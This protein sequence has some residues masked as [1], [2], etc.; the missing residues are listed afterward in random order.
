MPEI[1]RDFVVSEALAVT[2]QGGSFG[3]TV[4]PLASPYTKS[5]QAAP[6]S[7]PGNSPTVFAAYLS[8]QPAGVLQLSVHWTGFAL[9][10]ELAINHFARRQGAASALLSAAK[11]WAVAHGLLGLRVETQNTNVP[12]CKLYQACGFLLAGVD[13]ML[14]KGATHAAHEVALFWYWQREPGA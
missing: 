9:V 11:A 2:M 12:A 10:E 6:S 13:A 4:T 3:F 8:G 7:A 1:D 5:Y 14:Y